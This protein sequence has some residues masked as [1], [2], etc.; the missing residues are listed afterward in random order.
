MELRTELWVKGALCLAGLLAALW[1]WRRP[2]RLG[3][4]QAGAALTVLALA[5]ALAYFNFGRFH[6]AGLVHHWEQFHYVLGSKYF[7]ELGY[8][9]L[10]VASIAAQMVTSPERAVPPYLR[11]LRSNHVVETAALSRHGYDVRQRFSDDRWASFLRDHQVFLDANADEYLAKVRTDHGYNPTPA[12]TFVARLASGWRPITPAALRLLAWIDPLLLAV[13]FWM[14]FRTYGGLIGC[15]ALVVFGC[16]HPWRFDWVGGAFLRQDWLAAA[17]IAICMLQRKRW[18]LAGALFGYAAM[19]RIFPLLFLFGPVVVALREWV[20]GERPRWALRLAAGF[21]LAVALGLAAG[22]ATGRGPRA[23]TEFARNLEK[24]RA[25]WLTNNVGLD[26][27]LLYGPDT[28]GR[29][30][31]DWTAPEPWILWQGKMDL[32]RGERRPWLLLAALLYLLVTAAAAWR[33]PP[34]QAAAASVAAV[35]AL[36][37]LTCYYWSMLLWTPI[38]GG[39]RTA[40]GALGLSALLYAVQLRTGT[41]EMIYGIMSWALAALLLLWLLPA[42]WRTLRE[43][44]RAQAAPRAGRT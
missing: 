37:L 6:G 21:A 22:S 4:R 41:F 9:G 3:P 23:W 43:A 30:L 12:W 40:A 27:L 19:V 11:D 20:R 18:A 29:R 32:E 10:Y 35:F 36:L 7:P 17:G 2:D 28:F 13:L 8:D 1:R 42:A 44:R 16:G 39:P 38:R 26:N 15:L 14:I 24:H 33:A 25:A 5:S 31:V 34:D